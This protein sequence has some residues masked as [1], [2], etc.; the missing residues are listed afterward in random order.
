MSRTRKTIIAGATL[1][2]IVAALAWLFLRQPDVHAPSPPSRTIAST[3]APSRPH[4]LSSLLR[5]EDPANCHK[6]ETLSSIFETLLK[7]DP[8]TPETARAVQV[9]G[10]AEPITPTQLRTKTAEEDRFETILPLSGVWHGLKVTS[11]AVDAVEGSDNISDEIRFSDSAAHV[12]AVLNR[13]GFDLPAPDEWR[14]YNPEYGSIMVGEVD[15]GSAL[16]CGP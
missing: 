8:A 16:A 3:P 2:A 15:G 5:F 12:R 11:L 10:I 4:D 6:N 7:W 13:H 14:R 1:I 9:P